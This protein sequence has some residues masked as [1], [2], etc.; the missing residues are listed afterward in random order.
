[1]TTV[2]LSP[3]TDDAIFSLGAHLATLD[4]VTIVSVFAG[5]P[6]DP[7]GRAKHTLLRDEHADACRL[8]GATV[9]NGDFLD[10]VYPRT[11]SMEVFVQA[12]IHRYCVAV[13]AVYFPVGIHHPDHL[14]VSGCGVNLL[15]KIAARAFFYEE[16]P[17][18]MDYPE[19]ATRRLI[20]LAAANGQLRRQAWGSTLTKRAAVDCYQSQID[21]SVID[22]VMRPEYLWELQR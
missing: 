18:R 8:I 12:F 22:R 14:M 1:M 6:D 16:L 9:V 17:Y 4:D 20:D 13:D 19:I 21:A 7:G 11:P 3:H 5:I 2:V 10:D 15:P